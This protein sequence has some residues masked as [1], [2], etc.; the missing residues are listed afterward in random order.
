[1]VIKFEAMLVRIANIEKMLEAQILFALLLLLKGFVKS[2]YDAGAEKA[3]NAEIG[4]F[5]LPETLQYRSKGFSWWPLI[6]SPVAI[7]RP[8][9]Q[10]L[11][12]TE[13][14]LTTRLHQATH[15]WDNVNPPNRDRTFWIGTLHLRIGSIVA[16]HKETHRQGN[17]LEP[18]DYA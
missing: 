10:E 7:L 5:N 9:P 4:I 18:V 15:C 3:A 12:N 14:D 8:V 13:R 16:R 17:Y 1:M 11:V 6:H 2:R